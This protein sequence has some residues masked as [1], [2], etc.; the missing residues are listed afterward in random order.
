MHA[1][2]K[3][4]DQGNMK[5]KLY[6]TD[7]WIPSPPL[8]QKTPSDQYKTKKTTRRRQSVIIIIPPN[9]AQFL[10]TFLMNPHKQ[11]PCNFEDT[12][13][14]RRQEFQR[15]G[16]FGRS[17]RPVGRVLGQSFMVRCTTTPA[18]R[19]KQNPEPPLRWA[20]LLHSHQGRK[21]VGALQWPCFRESG[22]PVLIK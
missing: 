18:R 4:S 20:P 7:G 5:Y 3:S 6:G 15:S 14:D 11:R 13:N 21:E 19:V 8:Q 22:R 10:N 16:R 2:K 17:P 12:E 9:L 1:R